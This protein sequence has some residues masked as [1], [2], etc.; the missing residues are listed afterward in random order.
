VRRPTEILAATL[1]TV[2]VLALPSCGHPTRRGGRGA[3][4]EGPAAPRPPRM[5]YG[6]RRRRRGCRSYRGRN[7]NSVAAPHGWV[8]RGGGEGEGGGRI[9]VRL[10]LARGGWHGV[11]GPHG[12][13]NMV[14]APSGFHARAPG[15]GARAKVGGATQGVDAFVVLLIK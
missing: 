15:G 11:R 2:V 4:S 5:A 9:T 12:E 10:R 1:P 6:V 7:P 8:S 3:S 13:G 14:R